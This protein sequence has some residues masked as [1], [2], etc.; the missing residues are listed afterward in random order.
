MISLRIIFPNYVDL[1]AVFISQDVLL[2]SS[3]EKMLKGLNVYTIPNCYFDY[4]LREAGK[5]W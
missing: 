3:Q 1:Q 4:E 5:L 2:S